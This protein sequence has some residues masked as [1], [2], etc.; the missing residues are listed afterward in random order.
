MPFVPFGQYMPS[1]PNLSP[2]YSQSWNLS[3]QREV[4][5]GTLASLSYQGTGITHLQTSSP[6]NQ[7]IYV[8]GVGNATG[9][10]FLNG[11]ATPYKVNPGAVCSTTA[12]TQDRRTLSF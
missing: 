12:N 1:N 5:P 2:T 11:Q 6:L 10:C 8:P 3:F 7:A 4:V 9:N